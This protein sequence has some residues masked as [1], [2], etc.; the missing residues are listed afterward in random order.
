MKNISI[1]IIFIVMTNI[2]GKLIRI[3]VELIKFY[4]SAVAPR[5]GEK[6]TLYIQDG[7]I[8]DVMESAEEIDVF[9]QDPLSKRKISERAKTKD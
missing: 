2:S 9:I 7:S 3:N 6:T 4:E 1:L 8:I 5:W